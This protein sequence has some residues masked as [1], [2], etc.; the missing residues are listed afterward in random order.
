MLNIISLPFLANTDKNYEKE[1]RFSLK[2]NEKTL[3]ILGILGLQCDT[4]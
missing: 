4:C 1:F 3:C 2:E